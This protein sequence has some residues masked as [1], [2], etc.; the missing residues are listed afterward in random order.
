MAGSDFLVPQL[1]LCLETAFAPEPASRIQDFLRK[2][3]CIEREDEPVQTFTSPSCTQFR[4]QHEIRYSWQT[5]SCAVSFRTRV[6]LY[7]ELD[8]SWPGVSLD[9]WIGYST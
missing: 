2:L 8:A 1:N 7:T 9:V 6:P 5:F 4:N 3:A